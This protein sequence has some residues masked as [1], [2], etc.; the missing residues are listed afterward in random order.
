MCKS[1]FL[2]QSTRIDSDTL[3]GTQYQRFSQVVVY[4][5]VV[6][7]RFLYGYIHYWAKNRGRK[8]H[9]FLVHKNAAFLT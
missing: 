2:I 8:L 7:F 9:F 5:F 1:A 4:S 3:F 6:H